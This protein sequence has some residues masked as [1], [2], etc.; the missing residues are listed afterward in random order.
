MYLRVL[1]LTLTAASTAPAAYTQEPPSSRAL[2]E[3][4]T[5][6]CP[7]MVES[8]LDSPDMTAAMK[9]WPI[10]SAAVCTCTMH[11]LQSQAP[12][13]ASLKVDEAKFIKKLPSERYQSFLFASL[14]S[15]A[16]RCLSTEVDATL[17]KASP[18]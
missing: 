7:K 16:F 10:S 8:I 9:L 18:E 2:I 14:M 11:T 17:A 12:F 3:Q 15:A 6:A 13:A 4:L 1:A 5:A